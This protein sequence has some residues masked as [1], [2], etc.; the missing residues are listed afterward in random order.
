MNDF[1]IV[2]Q[3]FVKK[4]ISQGYISKWYLYS[5]KKRKK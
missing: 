5:D 4:T 3:L 2:F 1:R